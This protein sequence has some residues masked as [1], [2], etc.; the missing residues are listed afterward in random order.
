MIY[1]AP[2]IHLHAP[3]LSGQAYLDPGSGSFLLQLLIATL[4]GGLFVLKASW[5]KVKGFFLR[6]IGKNPPPTET[7]DRS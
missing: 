4:L 2:Y 3:L 7:E 1:L 5:G 6:L